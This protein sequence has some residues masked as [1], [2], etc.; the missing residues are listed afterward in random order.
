MTKGRTV[1]IQK[2]KAK[3]KEVGNYRQ[4]NCL[5]IAWKILTGI[6]AE[7]IYGSM[8]KKT[9]L[10]EEQNGG[11]KGSMGTAGLLYIDS[12]IM[13]EVKAR[14]RSIAFARIDYRKAYDMV[15]HSWIVECLEIIGINEEVSVC[16]K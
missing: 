1:S 12:M 7:E 4:V 5:P 11:R 10:P 9:M 6:L 13:K 14:R 15:P 3:G 16:M 2:D 8:V